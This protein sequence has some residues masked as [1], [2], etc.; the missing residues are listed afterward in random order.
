MT[1]LPDLPTA[2]LSRR[3]FLKLGGAAL[4]ALVWNPLFEHPG[5]VY[6]QD[7][8]ASKGR[9]LTS[10]LAL[11]KEPSRKSEIIRRLTFDL[12]LPITGVTVG[13]DEDAYNRVWYLVNQEGYVHSGGMQPV[14]VRLNEPAPAVSASGRLAE[15]T[16]PYTDALWQPRKNSPAA[17]R[18]YYSS[19]HWVLSVKKDDS[20]KSWYEI[21]DDKKHYHYWV[22]AAHLHLIEAAD[23]TVISPDVPYYEKR[24]EVRLQ[25]QVVIAYED[26]RPVF[27]SRAATGAHFTDGDYRT[28]PGRYQTN[29]KRPSRH[30]AAGEPGIGAGFDLPGVPWVCYLTKSGVSFHGTYWHNDFGNPR[31]HGCINLSPSAARWVYRWTMPVVPAGESLLEKDEGT[32]VDIL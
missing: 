26:E 29:R 17:Y 19:T 12:V 24:L 4:L 7:E 32:R 10:G 5:R 9:V 27:I 1:P 22:D 6:A 13:K 18:L 2:A 11:Y 25:E 8:P 20:G 16:V 14:E 23:L 3:S 30:M 15:V 21:F 31:S 28:A